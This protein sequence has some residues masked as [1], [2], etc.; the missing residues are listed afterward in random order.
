MLAFLHNLAIIKFDRSVML[1][2]FTIVVVDMRDP[3]VFMRAT[4]AK[5]VLARAR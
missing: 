2:R 5:S 3:A 4:L 1:R